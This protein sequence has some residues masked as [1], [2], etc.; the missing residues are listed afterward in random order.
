MLPL[1]PHSP[2]PIPSWLGYSSPSLESG[3]LL[4]L[5]IPPPLTSKHKSKADCL[6][7]SGQGSWLARWIVGGSYILWNPSPSPKPPVES[8]TQS[9]Q[10]TAHPHCQLTLPRPPGPE[11]VAS[12]TPRVGLHTQ[13]RSRSWC[14]V[15]GP[16]PELQP[17]LESPVSSGSCPQKG[18]LNPSLGAGW[19]EGG[20]SQG[21]QAASS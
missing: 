9:W 19:G 2:P 14:W 20:R 15:S 4:A 3:A 13:A 18:P 7:Q 16:H 11:V 1:P 6:I 10:A 21:E 8:L 17:Y 12:P 5:A